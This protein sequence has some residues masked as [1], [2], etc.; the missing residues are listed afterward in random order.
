MRYRIGILLLSLGVVVSG[1]YVNRASYDPFSYAPDT[2]C[3]VWE[4][5]RKA[6]PLA[7]E[8]SFLCLELPS[9]ERSL[10]LCEVLDIALLNNP[11]TKISWAQARQAAAQYGISQAPAFPQIEALFN[12]G[13]TRTAYLAS[14]VQPMGFTTTED[15]TLFESTQTLWGPRGT[16]SWTLLDFGQNRLT[17]EAARYALYFA[18]FSHNQALQTLLET[19]TLDYYNYLYEK[20][21][22]EANEAD[23]ANAEETLEAAELGLQTGAKNISDVLQARTQALLAEIQ[24]SQQQGNVTTAYA[25]LLDNMGLPANA[26]IL[27]QKLPFVDPKQV[28]LCPLQDYIDTA[29]QCRPS[30]L[31]A[32]ANLCSTQMSLSA[33]KR[34]WVPVLDYSV[35]IG[36][37]YFNSVSDGYDYTNTFTI[38]MPIF[39]GF[40]IRNTIR[41]ATA[42]VEEAEGTLEQTELEVIKDVTTAHYNVTVAFNTLKAANAL[43]VAAKQQYEVALSQ[44]KQGVNTI[45]DLVSAQTSLFD[46]R[47]KQ[48][49]AIRQWFSSLA[50]L[51]YSTGTLSQK[52]GCYS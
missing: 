14:Q 34:A 51:T 21:Q 16:L 25:V 27:V 31:A 30:L 48:A 1:C 9:S 8:E 4:P 15:N 52:P 10:S 41:N 20:K 50:N 33:A 39:T 12:F 38:T 2:P 35:N 37:T 26:T 23:L 18:D 17:S 22:L 40:N 46:A 13:T 3:T 7:C 19:V 42:T 36:R 24:L 5:D 45:L 32:R 29:M 11:Q 28:D 43:L 6:S 44:Y 47:A 49:D